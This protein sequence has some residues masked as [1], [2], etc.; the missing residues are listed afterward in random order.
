[1][2]IGQVT[3]SE[4]CGEEVHDLV[5]T[6]KFLDIRATSA[7]ASDAHVAMKPVQACTKPW[8]DISVISTALILQV[9]KANELYLNPQVVNTTTLSYH[10]A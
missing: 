6:L 9:Q 8:T 10:K 1:M 4:L 3:L 2:A 5:Q 7:R